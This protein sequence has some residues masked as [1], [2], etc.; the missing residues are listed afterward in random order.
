MSKWVNLYTEKLVTALAEQELG[1]E[2]ERG[3]PEALILGKTGGE[4]RQP[5]GAGHGAR[6]RPPCLLSCGTRAGQ[7]GLEPVREDNQGTSELLDSVQSERLSCGER[8]V[9]PFSVSSNE[10]IRQLSSRL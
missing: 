2:R 5:G 4:Q 3:K 9:L 10:F 8:K 6:R 7:L 1:R